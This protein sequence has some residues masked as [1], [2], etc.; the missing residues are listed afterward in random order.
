MLPSSDPSGPALSIDAL[1]GP[2]FGVGPVRRVLGADP[3]EDFGADAGWL[4]PR[5]RQSTSPRSPIFREGDVL[6]E[7]ERLPLPPVAVHGSAGGQ[8][9]PSALE[10]VWGHLSP[11]SSHPVSAYGALSMPH[12]ALGREV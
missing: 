4:V 7:P 2:T 9:L 1:D 8:L 3:G 12:R 11:V 5:A 6:E 10:R